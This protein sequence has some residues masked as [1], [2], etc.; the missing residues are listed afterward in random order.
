MSASE[1]SLETELLLACARARAAPAVIRE[2]A[3]S[4]IDWPRLLGLAQHHALAPLVS[5]RLREACAEAVPGET[6][7]AL[8]ECFRRNVARSL[9]LT[10]E[11]LEILGVLRAAGVS[12]IPFK[13]PV[14]AWW[15]YGHP[16]LREFTDLDL[17]V[18]RKDV[19]R[20]REL[21]GARGYRSKAALDG[22][23]ERTFLRWSC[24]WPLVRQDERAAVDLHWGIVP[25]Y[26]SLRLEAEPLATVAVAGREI[27]TF[28]PEDTLLIL[29]IHGTKHCWMPLGLLCDLAMLIETAGIDWERVLARAGA[30]GLRRR[31]LVG[32]WLARELLGAA[33]PERVLGRLAAEARALKLASEIR[34]RFLTDRP[35]SGESRFHLRS[36]DRMR[37]RVRFLLGTIFEPT[38][39]DWD[40]LRIPPSLFP[41]YYLAR[42]LRLLAKHGSR[43][44]RRLRPRLS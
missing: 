5:W 22:R 11:L 43:Q 17:L 24:Q 26:F 38:E 8:N 6:L 19:S 29:V 4:R 18:R 30:L 20:V 41:L 39:A 36:M 23:L 31:L 1:R 37:D 35:A 16:G 28:G 15:L 10:G 33:L 21:L 7:D 13:G 42:P 25:G 32:L 40:S 12:A 9:F 2:L 14:L 34:E 3:S 27:P 44:A